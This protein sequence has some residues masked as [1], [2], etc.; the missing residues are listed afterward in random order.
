MLCLAF[1]A[2]VALLPRRLREGL[3]IDVLVGVI[4]LGVMRIVLII[5]TLF[6][7]MSAFPRV[8]HA[9]QKEKA[10]VLQRGIDEAMPYA[11][12]GLGF[13]LPLLLAA[14]FAD[15]TLLKRHRPSYPAAATAPAGA[16]CATHPS[17]PAKLICARCGGFMCARCG[18]SHASLCGS[19]Q[20][21]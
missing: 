19:C 5:V 21:R 2:C 15:R 11:T 17:E 8:A 12:F 13:E 1:I 14:W 16:A 18:A 7:L 20:A 9:A 6:V 10:A 3:P 4:G